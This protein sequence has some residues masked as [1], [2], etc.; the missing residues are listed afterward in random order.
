MV[1]VDG[2]GVEEPGEIVVAILAAGH[3]VV[4]EEIVEAIGVE[5][6]GEDIAG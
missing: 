3:Q 4:A 6:A 5:L 2:Q 1:V